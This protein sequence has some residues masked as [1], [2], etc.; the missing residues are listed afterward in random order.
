MPKKNFSYLWAVLCSVIIADNY[1]LIGSRKIKSD[2][3]HSSCI[4]SLNL[5][6]LVDLIL[7]IFSVHLPVWQKEAVSCC[8]LQL[9]SFIPF[10][11]EASFSTLW[12]LCRYKRNPRAARVYILNYLFPWLL[13]SL[14]QPNCHIRVFSTIMIVLL[15]LCSHFILNAAMLRYC[16]NSK[17]NTNSGM[18]MTGKLLSLFKGFSQHRS[19]S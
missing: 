4:L 7:A 14:R 17:V 9:F 16:N 8:P 18:H 5:F 11:T 2:A 3:S 19:L 10:L 1:V 12:K 6:S 15:S 13:K